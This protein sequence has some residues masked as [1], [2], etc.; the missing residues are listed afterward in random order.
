MIH[1]LDIHLFVEALAFCA[2]HIDTRNSFLILEPHQ[3]G[4]EKI[5]MLIEKMAVSDGLR[6]MK[7]KKFEDHIKTMGAVEKLDLMHPFRKRYQWYFEMREHQ[8]QLNR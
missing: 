2:L 7:D 4:F 8:A 3:A 1:V 5:L 6:R